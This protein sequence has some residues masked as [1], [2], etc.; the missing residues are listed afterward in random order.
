M[1]SDAM[2]DSFGAQIFDCALDALWAL[3]FPSV[4]GDTQ[5]VSAGIVK[6]FG[7]FLRWII[8]L[9]TSDL[10]LCDSF[11]FLH[12][13]GLGDLHRTFDAVAAVNG[14]D[15]LCFY[16]VVRLG[17]FHPFEHGVKHLAH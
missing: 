11:S 17:G 8:D 7:K 10:W 9:V 15:Q 5:T 3:G 6:Y 1:C 14:G 16:T 4:N 13:G 2:S 12:D